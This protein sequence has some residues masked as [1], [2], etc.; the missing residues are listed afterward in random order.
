MNPKIKP[1][2]PPFGA[3]FLLCCL[4]VLARIGIAGEPRTLSLDQAT[5]MKCI[6]VLEQALE[7]DDFWPSMHAAEALTRAGHAAQVRQRLTPKLPLETDDQHRCGLARELV[8]AG[9]RAKIAVMLDILDKADPYAHGHACESL[10]KVNEIGDGRQLLTIL[11]DKSNP[12][13]ALMAAAALGRWGNPSAFEL[14]RSS[15]GDPDA[16]LARVA[17]WVL[18]RIGDPQD[19]PALRAAAKRHVDPLS[20]AYFSNAMAA[21]GDTQGMK[22]LAYN[23]TSNDPAIRTYAAT[24]AADSRAIDLKGPLINMLDDTNLDARV[25]AAESL[26]VLAQA[27]PAA[28]GDVIVNDVFPATAAHPRYSEGSVMALRDGRLLLAATEFHGSASD[29]GKAHIVGRSS[30][31]GG[32]HWS[33]TMELQKN[34]GRQNVMSVTLRRLAPPTIDQW[35]IGMFFLVKNS[36]SDLDVVLRISND[37]TTTFSRQIKVTDVPGYH[38]MN[39]DRVAR[40][41]SGRLICPVA[42]TRDVAKANHFVA[43]CFLSDDAGRT[44]RQSRTKVDYA[45]RG[46]MEPEVL[47]LDDGR[48]IMTLRTQLGH[49]A[50]SYS[51]DQGDTWTP[52]VSWNVRSPESPATLRRIPSTG[53]LLLIWNDNFVA[54]AD[55]G[56]PRWP[57]TVAISSDNGTTWKHKQNFELAADTSYSYVSAV[58]DRGRLLMTYYVRSD[59]S[60]LISMRFRSVPIGALYE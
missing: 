53:D 46:A 10:Y 3:A 45:R 39:N 44:W 40:L 51:I 19:I 58:F 7:A 41:H 23:L 50:V 1:A 48:L 5:N 35:P 12:R 17:A 30:A 34:E 29:F 26:L 11:R 36:P 42:S 60:G 20:Q 38:V 43:S 18:A 21:L 47:Q 9:D 59:K 54:G 56:G 25:R 14:L 4:G 15:V 6:A 55:H 52:A 16:E 13:G 49:I 24:F 33:D 8:R 37:E 22:Q 32:R 31:D 27:A 57:L 2:R 28:V